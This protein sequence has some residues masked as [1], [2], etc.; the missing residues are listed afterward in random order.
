MGNKHLIFLFL[1]LALSSCNNKSQNN[2]TKNKF[3]T[4]KEFSLKLNKDNLKFKRSILK[5]LEVIEFRT[6]F[7]PV[8]HFQSNYPNSDTIFATSINS[9]KIYQFD[10]LLKKVSVLDKNGL[11]PYEFVNPY[12]VLAFSDSLVFTDAGQRNV[13]IYNLKN[14]HIET[15]L[16]NI[17]FFSFALKNNQLLYLSN[18]PDKN[19]INQLFFTKHHLNNKK[20]QINLT[21]KLNLP[22]NDFMSFA[23]QGEFRQNK[24]HVLYFGWYTSDIFI[25]DNNFNFIKTIKTIDNSQPP[26]PFNQKVG[27]YTAL[28]INREK[29]INLDMTLD[30]DNIYILSNINKKNIYYIDCYNIDKTQSYRGSYEIKLSQEQK[31]I[32]IFTFNNKILVLFEDY[33]LKVYKL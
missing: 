25:F 8:T 17:D 5:P 26:K 11:G 13:K 15:I 20:Q 16:S 9:S 18:L 29:M 6:N 3:L 28:N 2:K 27:N 14:Q 7:V 19:S 33:N 4:Q 23:Y 10:D 22:K 24:N 32:N 1:F 12:G 30:D 21:E 31:P